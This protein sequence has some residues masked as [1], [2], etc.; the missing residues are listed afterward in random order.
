MV[1]LVY[2]VG[3]I[4]LRMV[5]LLAVGIL[6]PLWAQTHPVDHH[7]E[8]GF[9][10]DPELEQL[11][12]LLRAK[13]FDEV[14]AQ[15]TRIVKRPTSAFKSQK[16]EQFV[17]ANAL[18]FGGQAAAESGRDEEA[19]GEFRQSAEMG[20]SSAYVEVAG[21]LTIQAA[22]Q[23]SADA[24]KKLF[25]EAQH[26]YEGCAELGDPACMDILAKTYQKLNRKDEENYWFLLKQM[27]RSAAEME[28][29]D[30]FYKQQFTDEDRAILARVMHERSLSGGEVN[31]PIK[32]LPGRST[33]TS[34]FVDNLMRR[35]LE[36][37][38]RAFFSPSASDESVY[39]SFQHYRS[40][41]PSNPFAT[42]YLLVPQAVGST[43]DTIVSLLSLA[44]LASNLLSGDEL[45]VR[46]GPLTH[47]AVLWSLDSKKDVLLLD[48]FYEFW[49]P[50]HNAC[51]KSMKLVPYR[52]RRDLVQIPFA[53]LKNM[54]QGVITV[55]DRSIRA[56][57]E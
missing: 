10:P 4:L 15:A 42:A 2:E 49:Q 38:W 43:D 54:L 40:H 51:I 55:R 22:S 26:Y 32:R 41:V 31:S 9:K 13:R 57:A 30:R 48:P 16:D 14:R 3:Q 36:F 24:R 28:N 35:Q 12:S 1:V 37:V 44:D 19:L 29:V 45:F 56:R 46:C 20:K 33:L 53:D 18:Y 39:Q 25:Y 50:S 47:A 8:E 27:N 11:A 7:G 52:Y 5:L 23:S 6:V 21:R 34:A 17:K